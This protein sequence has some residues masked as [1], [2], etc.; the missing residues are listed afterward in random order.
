IIMIYDVIVVGAGA[1][2]LHCSR[3]LKNVGYSVLTLEANSI[4]GGRTRVNTTFTQ[5]PVELG[6]EMIHGADTL[7]YNMAKEQGWETF[8]VFPETLFHDEEGRNCTYFYLGRERRLVSQDQI[9]DDMIKCF[10]ELEALSDITPLPPKHINLMQHLASKGVPFRAIGLAD[11]V[12]SKTW[13]TNLDRIGLRQA[14][15]EDKKAHLEPRNFKLQKSSKVLVDYLSKD[16][17][18]RTNWRVKSIDYTGSVT[19][20][21]SYDGQ[22]VQGKKVAVCVPLTVLK[23]KDIKFEPEL[24]REK[25][26]ALEVM[27]MDGGMKILLKFKEKFW[28]QN[29]ELVLCA[30]SPVPQ[31]WMDGAPKR[32]VPA[33]SPAEFVAVG[34]I[35]GDQARSMAAL[36]EAKAVRAFLDQLDAMFGVVGNWT[37]ASQNYIG[38]FVYDWQKNP[39]V[40]G[41]YSFPCVIPADSPV[42]DEP[43]L[44]LAKRVSDKIFFAGEATATQ[45]E[46]ATIN[47]ALQTGKR[48]FEEVEQSLK[49]GSSK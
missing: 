42:Q 47:G 8:E 12:Y 4:I 43:N 34:F 27:Q 46:M 48:A 49:L 30:D 31:V 11:A 13:G 39:F 18:I 28:S 21:S 32:P 6:G 16:L 14:C 2:G 33:G 40:R 38:H 24:P 9:D 19:S 29:L 10:T 25:N 45:F 44:I 7:Y 36:P 20:I 1:A 22:V 37:P 17:E 15:I 3:L 5:W 41:A 26:D 23:E 35:T